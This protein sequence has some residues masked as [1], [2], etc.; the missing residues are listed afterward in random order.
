MRLSLR[1]VV[2][3]MLALAAFAYA[4]VPLTDA[5]MQRWFARD[6]A[7][8]SSLIA[9]TVQEPLTDLIAAGFDRPDRRPSSTG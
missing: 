4:A 8:R 5:L 3:L 1:F 2:P 9:A 6:L 7:M